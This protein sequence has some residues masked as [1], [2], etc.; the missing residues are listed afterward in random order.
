MALSTVAFGRLTVPLFKSVLNLS[1]CDLARC[2][3]AKVLGPMASVVDF[4]FDFSLIVMH[5]WLLHLLS[6]CVEF[7]MND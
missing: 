5:V 6:Y 4:D 1:G 2:A 3:E 7:A